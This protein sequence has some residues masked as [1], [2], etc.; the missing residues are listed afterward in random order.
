MRG[1]IRIPPRRLAQAQQL[2]QAGAIVDEHPR[3][4]RAHEVP[5]G[6]GHDVDLQAL[7]PLQVTSHLHELAQFTSLQLFWP[8]STLQAA[9][10]HS[11]LRQPWFPEHA[12]VQPALS[13]QSTPLHALLPVQLIVQL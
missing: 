9:E 10:P 13:V 2:V 8:H 12:I 11:M 3:L 7:K 4:P 5:P 6:A 1:R